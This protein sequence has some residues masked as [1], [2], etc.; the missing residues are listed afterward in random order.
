MS[1]TNVDDI[2]EL[3]PLQQGMLLHTVHDGATDM[4]LGQH[5]YIV[6]GSLDVEAMVRAWRKVFESHPALRTSFHWDGNDKPLQVVHRDV[7]PPAHQDDWSALSDDEQRERLDAMMA[8]DRATGFD[9]AAAPLQRLHLIRLGADRHALAWTHHHLLL[10]GWSVPIFMNE[11][12]AHYQSLTGGGPLPP[13]APPFRDYIA[14]LQ[15][16]D[17]DAARTFWKEVMDGVTAAPLAGMRPP[18]PR[19]GTGGVDRHVV[20]LP[21]AVEEGLREAA[22]RHRVTVNTVLHAAWA[23][24]LGRY[25]GRS[26]IVFGCVSSGRPAE[27]PGVDRMIGM[28]VNTLPVRL[29]VPRDGDLGP[30]LHELQAR[31]ADIR[32]Y[33]FSPLSDIKKWAGAP[34]QQLFDSLFVLDN[35]S[36]GVQGGDSPDQQLTVRSQTTY[37]KVSVPMALIVTPAPVSEVQLLLHEDRFEPGFADGI[38]DCLFTTLKAILAADRVEQVVAAAGPVIAPPEA[39]DPSSLVDARSGPVVPPATPE[40]EAIAAVY[41]DILELT[42]VDVTTSFFDLGGDSFGAVRAVGRIEGA[43]VTLLALNPSVRALATALAAGGLTS[44]EDELDAEI[45][46][47]ERQLAETDDLAEDLTAFYTTSEEDE[48]EAA[49]SGHGRLEFE[50]T[51][52]ILL[53]HLPPAPAVIADI[54]GGT[55]RY[56]LWLADLGYRVVHRDIVPLYVEQ[57]RAAIR[58]DTDV[59]TAVGDARSLDLADESVAAVLLLGPLY[60]LPR[61]A[62]RVQVLREARRIVAPGGTVFASAIS[63]WAAR[64]DGVLRERIYERGPEMLAHIDQVEETGVLPPL[65]RGGYTAYTHRPDEL[66]SEFS[67]AGLDMTDLVSVEGTAFLLTDLTER[68]DDPRGHE[69]ILASARAHERVP[70]LLGI[71]PHLVATGRRP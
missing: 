59:E 32:R 28:F 37:D 9:V 46:E 58:P 7:T 44:E 67:S 23:V 66:Q 39:H 61:L 20:S 68:M 52:E 35:H 48:R 26:D 25:S 54:G 17:M 11:V 16:Q 12:M 10:D 19:Q 30:W 60:H 18:D 34:G 22:S 29:S 43:S 24:V 45:A 36:F 69:A 51:Q 2:Y 5:V 31:Y 40:E 3:S 4:Y 33:E 71:G 64:M 53:R 70:E 21:P 8:E 55:G 41:R 13:P 14:W 63:R 65:A 15:R 57:L 49:A 38:L 27:L 50:R 62:D 1:T 47:L 42:E 6:E 56:A